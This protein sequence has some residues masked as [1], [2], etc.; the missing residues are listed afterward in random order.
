MNKILAL[1]F[2]VVLGCSVQTVIAADEIHWTITG[3]NSVNISWHGDATENT[4]D[5][6]LGAAAK[7][8]V[9]AKRPVPL[10]TSATGTI[11]EVNLS[12]LKENSLYSYSIGNNPEQHFKTP[13][14]PGL[15]N[16]T[17]YAQGT[18][19]DTGHFFNT[20]IVQELVSDGIPDFVL[21]LGDL[22]LGSIYG[23]K[24]AR[25]HFNDVMT[26]SKDAAYMPVWGDLDARNTAL[27]SFKNYKGRFTLPNPQVSPGSPAAGGEDWY[28]FDYGNTRFITL[29]EP[30]VGAWADWKT[31]VEKLM[32]E[33]Q[34]NPKIKFIVTASH[35]SAYSSGHFAGSQ[36]LKTILDSLGDRYSKYVLSMNSHSSDYERTHPQ[37]GVVHV[38]AGIGGRDLMQDGTCLWLTCTKPAWSAYRAMHHGA[39]KLFFS[40]TAI[41]GSFIC[42]P[43]GGGV[44]DVKC[45]KGSILDKFTITA[46]N[47]AQSGSEG[48]VTSGNQTAVTCNK[49]SLGL[50]G[51]IMDGGFAYRVNRTFGIPADS[52]TSWSRSKLR[53]FEN[54]L[55][56]GPGHT[57]HAEIRSTGKGRFSHWT[58]DSARES[59]RFSATDNTNPSTNGK[60]YSYCIDSTT[61]TLD[62]TTES[63]DTTAPSVP[64]AVNA[65]A[66]SESQIKLSWAQS[67]DNV[68]VTGYRIYRNQTQLGNTTSLSFSDTGLAAGTSYSYTVEAYDAASNISGKSSTVTATTTKV[69]VSPPATAS[70]AITPPTTLVVDVT[71]KGAT[72][73][74]ATND[75]AAIQSAIDQVAISGGTVYVPDGTFMIDAIKRIMMKSNVTLKMSSGTVLKAIANNRQIYDVIR[76]ENVSNVNIIGGTVQ[77][78]RY[79]HTG[80]GGEW[81]HGIE[82]WGAKNVVI[83]GV[84]TKE[85]WGD[86]I[87]VS[88][89]AANITI[90][91]VISDNNRRQGLTITDVNGALVKNSVFKNTNGTIPYAG[92]DIEPN[93]SESVKNV[94]IIN[95][96]MSNNKGPGIQFGF[97]SANAVSTSSIANV[98]VDGNLIANNGVAGSNYYASGVVIARLFNS[99]DV[100]ISNNMVKN[101]A[102]DGII[103]VDGTKNVRV[104][105]NT[106][107]GSGIGNTIDA[108][109]GNGLMIWGTGTNNNV[110]INNTSTGNKVNLI[111]DS[112]TTGNIVSPNIIR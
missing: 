42:G 59:L 104:T 77:G 98:T 65:T 68:G 62:P 55:E 58:D 30:W 27:D 46:K 18:I 38:T 66:V 5:Y 19:G 26:W 45:T 83:E 85:A 94:K 35:R 15:A 43:A 61:T 22:S 95:N 63:K 31:K 67:T 49:I 74:D 8:R 10:P 50:S 16:F 54:G 4:L 12:G 33:A 107:T 108:H 40:D 47:T 92:I 82:V 41:V 87:Y 28:S 2:A 14:T 101:S 21:G 25:Q 112:S 23:L 84:T 80:T 52:K 17:V 89:R 75:T 34:A 51:L 93:E 110:I 105:G 86:G 111:V 70:C 11:W 69:I 7:T 3:Q 73:N 9:V 71:S 99:T 13:P 53:L 91:S 79:T 81:G 88:A 36:A 100:V 48:G 60:A 78:D 102:Q 106:V 32:A 57:G 90:C 109:I 103:L 56:I 29:P 64:T 24:S 97:S 72:P 44:N 96:Q 37:H 39:L 20:G 76:V 1:P 6:R